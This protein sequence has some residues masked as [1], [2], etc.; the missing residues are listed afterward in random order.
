MAACCTGSFLPSVFDSAWK[1]KRLLH[2]YMYRSLTEASHPLGVILTF[3]KWWQT[4]L[5]VHSVSPFLSLPTVPIA[6]VRYSEVIGTYTYVFGT[7]KLNICQR[8]D[9]WQIF[10]SLCLTMSPARAVKRVLI[11]V[12]SSYRYSFIVK[13]ARLTPL[14]STCHWFCYCWSTVTEWHTSDCHTEWR[15]GTASR[16]VHCESHRVWQVHYPLTLLFGYTHACGW[17]SS[18]YMSGHRQWHSDDI[19]CIYRLAVH[20]ECSRIVSDEWSDLP[21]QC[22]GKEQCWGQRDIHWHGVCT[23]WVGLDNGVWCA[24]MYT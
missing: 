20:W 1:E 11:V 19:H 15:W 23:L 16:G 2:C 8:P 12:G 22:G 5:V 10:L 9:S 6:E 3:Q 14:Y 13:V 18:V 21:C 7:T 24:C 17:F 4:A